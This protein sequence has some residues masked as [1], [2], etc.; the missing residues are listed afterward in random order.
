MKEFLT[1]MLSHMPR[2]WLFTYVKNLS[3]T[4]FG[5][6]PGCILKLVSNCFW[7]SRNEWIGGRWSSHAI[8]HR[9]KKMFSTVVCDCLFYLLFQRTLYSASEYDIYSYQEA[10]SII[11]E[12]ISFQSQLY[13]HL[14]YTPWTFHSNNFVRTQPE[15]FW[16]FYF[17]T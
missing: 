13:R 1:E 9:I 3:Q 17:T 11:R 12:R 15:F 5:F 14:Q 2:D 4:A 8:S 7:G 10:V 6:K 16:F